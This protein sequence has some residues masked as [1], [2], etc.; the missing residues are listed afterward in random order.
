MIMKN[1]LSQLLEQSNK[2]T[3]VSYKNKDKRTSFDESFGIKK[4]EIALNYI[5]DAENS[6]AL[7]KK[8]AKV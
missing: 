6:L 8:L 1:T 5:G 4:M 7:S 2:K 3:K